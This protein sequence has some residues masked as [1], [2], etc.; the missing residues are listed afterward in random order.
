[1]EWGARGVIAGCK[2]GGGEGAWRRRGG[3]AKVGRG[4][5]GGGGRGM[6]ADRCKSVRV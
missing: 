5:G 3:G 1:M 2:G 6:Q 4:G